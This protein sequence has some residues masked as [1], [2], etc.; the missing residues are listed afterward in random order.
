MQIE[1][2]DSIDDDGDDDRTIL[3]LVRN[4]ATLHELA[5]HTLPIPIPRGPDEH[6][7]QVHAVAL[8]HG[9][10][11]WA[12]PAAL[13]LAIP[14]YEVAGTVVL[15]P[16]ASPFQPGT[17]VYACTSLARPGSAREYTIAL[18]SEMSQKPENL[19]WEEAAT[20]PLSALTAWQALF[21]HGGLTLP[22]APPPSV[23]LSSSSLT[24][25]EPSSL[26][27]I[28]PPRLSSS[29][30]RPT[31]RPTSRPASR[32]SSSRPSS[33]SSS[34]ATT[35]HHR[36]RHFFSDDT[37]ANKRVLITAAAGGVG[38]WAVQLARLAGVGHITAT[39][40]PANTDF[41]R[42][43]GAHRVVDYT[44][45]L[46]RGSSSGSSGGSGRNLPAQGGG[47]GSSGRPR[48]VSQPRHYG[49]GGGGSG[50]TSNG[51]VGGG[52]GGS[53]SSDKYDLVLDGVGTTEALRR[54]W[55]SAR[56]G[57]TV[58][59][60]ATPADRLRPDTGVG[61]DVKSVWFRVQA[62]SRQLQ[63]VTDLI[64]RKAAKAHFDSAFPLEQYDAAVARAQ[65]VHRRGKVV[66]HLA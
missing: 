35:T 6:L 50:G 65:S 16:K 20:V 49:G 61:M 26:P 48:S 7:V 28:Q 8:T 41:V 21:V 56:H 40:G 2:T 31:S 33:S 55:T 37:N 45:A 11:A 12:E 22:Q 66:L 29:S 51:I 17:E 5:L 64:E 46:L 24:Q 27:P 38:L 62:D 18:T 1:N 42:S 14:G 60:V 58:I 19:S 57:G 15:A 53:S 4:P 9:E 59:S 36:P 3:A 39:C 52:G 25:N 34:S 43:L 32:P 44:A 63:A 54:A 23:I 13:N 10:L 30:S 47:G